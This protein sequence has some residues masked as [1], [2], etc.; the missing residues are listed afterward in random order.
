MSEV[1]DWDHVAADIPEDGLNVERA[2]TENERGEIS[3]TLDLVACPSFFARYAIKPR[4]N[5]NFR[6]EGSLEATVEQTCVVTLEPL[7]NKIAQ[8]FAVDFWPESELPEPSG[9]LVDVH[10][11]PDMEPIV[12]GRIEAGRIIF[13]CL[14]SSIDLFPRKPGATFEAPPDGAQDTGGKSG[15]PFAALAKIRPK[16]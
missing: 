9:G 14:A 4:S 1:L 16:Q 13:E 5:G 8:T 10:D 3:R 2:A 15:G 7:T 6:L 11:E 12:A